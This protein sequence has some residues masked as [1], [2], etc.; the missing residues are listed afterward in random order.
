MKFNQSYLLLLF[1][2]LIMNSACKKER[3]APIQPVQPIQNPGALP[4]DSIS[5]ILIFP[6]AIVVNSPT[7]PAS[8]AVS[9]APVINDYDQNI[10]YTAGSHLIMPIDVSGISEITGVYI[11]V[12]GASTYF[13]MPILPGMPSN[14]FIIPAE[15]PLDL[16]EGTFTLV[17]KFYDINKKVSL[18]KEVNITITKINNCGVTKVS[19]GQGLTSNLFRIPNTP[20]TIKISYETFTIKDK[21]DVFQ[22]GAW[23][24]GTGPITDRITLKKAANCSVATEDKGYV[25]QKSEFLFEVDPNAGTEIEVVVSGCENGGTLWEYTFSCPGSSVSVDLP[26][27]STSAISAIQSTSASSGGN[28]TS[29]NGSPVTA[30][31]VVWSTSINPTIALDTKISN[32]SGVGMFTSAIGNLTANTKY[33]VRAFATNSAGTAYGNE[34]SFTTTGAIVTNSLDGQWLSSGGTGVNISGTSAPLYVVAGA[35]QRAEAAGLL[36]IGDIGL[37]NIVK[38]SDNNWECQMLLVY[39]EGGVPKAVFWSDTLKVTM[40]ADGQSISVNG[41][42]TYNGSIS[43]VSSTFTR[44]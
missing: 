9:E 35:Y 19:G 6:D 44:Q 31:G 11:Q 40:S 27:L 15:L 43:Y 23:I 26:T 16:G 21:I 28:V 20:G 42:G 12:K 4:P 8:S 25:G 1:I 13:D 37:S 2:L 33:Y 14:P 22:N 17:L 30:R 36:K 29:E 24:G 32:G 3:T 10:S 38:V 39:S 5:N 34:V 41:Q 7:L 18:S